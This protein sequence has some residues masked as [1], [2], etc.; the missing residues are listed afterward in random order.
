MQVLFLCVAFPSGTVF[1]AR[2]VPFSRA[3]RCHGGFRA[4]WAAD[5]C[6]G[7]YFFLFRAGKDTPFLRRTATPVSFVL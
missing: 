4:D 5:S 2:L 6:A 1:R 3:E 7:G